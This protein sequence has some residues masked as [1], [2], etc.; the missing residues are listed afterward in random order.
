MPRIH[1]YGIEDSLHSDRLGQMTCRNERKRWRRQRITWYNSIQDRTNR[2]LPLL[3]WMFPL[4]TNVFH[5]LFRRFSGVLSRPLPSSYSNDTHT[6]CS[7]LNF[8]LMASIFISINGTCTVSCGLVHFYSC[9]CVEKL[10]L[11]RIM[12]TRFKPIAIGSHFIFHRSRPALILFVFFYE[13]AFF[14]LF[15]FS[16]ISNG[17]NCTLTGHLLWLMSFPVTV[18]CDKITLRQAIIERFHFVSMYVMLKALQ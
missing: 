16:A 18:E 10:H 3:K 7:S 8:S 4:W 15:F 12:W 14:F 2:E 17:V 6:L 13:Y 11:A 1:R 5:R 9:Y